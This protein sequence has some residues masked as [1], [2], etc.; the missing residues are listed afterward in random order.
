MDYCCWLY[1]CTAP[2]M[3]KEETTREGKFILWSLP[4]CIRW[5]LHVV[6]EGKFDGRGAQVDLVSLRA[7]QIDIMFEYVGSEVTL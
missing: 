6:V 2:K 7:L 5:Y 3:N 4:V 1:L